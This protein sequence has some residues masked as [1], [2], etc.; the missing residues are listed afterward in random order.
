MTFGMTNAPATFQ[1]TLN[2][3][4]NQHLNVN[5]VVYM[6]NILIF[7]KTE[8]EHKLHLQQVFDLLAK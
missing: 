2:N 7:L 6:D 1:R 5:I 8:V 3:L 4:F